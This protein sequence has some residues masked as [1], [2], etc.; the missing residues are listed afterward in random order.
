MGSCLTLD[1]SIV[2]AKRLILRDIFFGHRCTQSMAELILDWKTRILMNSDH[3]FSAIR[4]QVKYPI[5]NEPNSPKWIIFS[6]EYTITCHLSCFIY[7]FILNISSL[8]HP[9]PYIIS[10]ERFAPQI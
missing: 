8:A 5:L 6:M 3:I 1:T 10:S 7:S 2:Q 9:L 4:L